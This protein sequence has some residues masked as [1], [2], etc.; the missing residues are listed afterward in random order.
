MTKLA[1]ICG[2]RRSGI[3]FALAAT[4]ALGAGAVPASSQGF[5]AVNYPA[6]ALPQAPSALASGAAL[7]TAGGTVVPRATAEPLRLSLDDAIGL[8]LK[9]NEQL[10]Q[11]RIQERLVRG[12]ILTAVQALLPSLTAVAQ[13]NAQEINLAAMGFK[14]ASLAG[15]GI[16]TAGFSTIVKVKTT[17]AQMNV[18]QTLF[19]LPSYYLFRAAQK[20]AD[21]GSLTV[22]NGRGAVTLAVGT[23]YLKA[24]ADAAQS[25]D[26]AALLRSDEAVLRQATLRHEA[27][28]SPNIDVL[29]ARVQMQEQQQ[30]VIQAEDTFA[31]DT[32]TLDR[33]MG[34][35]AGQQ[36]ALTDAVPYADLAERPLAE[37]LA[38]AYTR[39][40]DLLVLQAEV[41]AVEREQKAVR[42]ERLPTV[43]FGGFYG[44]IGETAGLYHGNF[45]AQGSVKIPL[46]KEAQFR[47]EREVADSQRTLL[48]QQVASLRVTID[49][50]IRAS[51]LD[52]ASTAELVKVARSNVAL[53]T[54][55]LGDT[56]ERFKAGVD[57]SLPVVRAQATL[58]DAEA[59]LIASTFQNNQAKLLLARNMGLVETQYRS[60]LGR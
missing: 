43:G 38:L 49:E 45:V 23:A 10:E 20:A 25:V 6:D 35:P 18:Q 47:G 33:Q 19:D 42:Y 46:F 9:Q 39:R 60:F 30:V 44:V 8:G 51:L 48:R 13:T 36:L 21:A 58:A 53:A 15:L 59:R 27:G 52:V 5:T 41:E 32:I 24:L 54:E 4:L 31:K 3:R 37:A 28:V 16:P 50:E 12:Q 29:R 57:D 7:R 26:A 14:A 2:S 11:L 56:A 34:L 55:A 1:W 17:S 22:L 40:K